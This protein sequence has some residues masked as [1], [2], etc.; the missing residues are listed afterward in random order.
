[1]PANGRRDLIRRLK[2]KTVKFTAN[3]NICLTVGT[4][5]GILNICTRRGKWMALG[6]ACFASGQ[7]Q[8]GT[9]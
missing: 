1:M 2:I 5:S 9:Q 3:Q 6:P 7:N 8:P 4:A